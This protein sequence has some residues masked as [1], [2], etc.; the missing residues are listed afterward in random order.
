M[1]YFYFHKFDFHSVHFGIEDYFFFQIQDYDCVPEQEH[2][3]FDINDF[4]FVSTLKILLPHSISN[5]FVFNNALH[6]F[7]HNSLCSSID[8]CFD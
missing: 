4:L 7:P 8:F 6:D 2:Y 1:L 3:N 5:N